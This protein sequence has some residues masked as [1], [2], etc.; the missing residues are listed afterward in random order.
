MEGL[1]PSGPLGENSNRLQVLILVGG[2]AVLC[3]ALM[4]GAVFFLLQAR[5]ELAAQV[6]SLIP[7]TR[8]PVPTATRTRVPEPSSTP[9]PPP[10]AV[11]PPTEAPPVDIQATLAVQNATAT[12]Q[13]ERVVAAAL[14]A[15]AEWPIVIT[16]NFPADNPRGWEVGTKADEYLSV[17]TQL[18][19]AAYQWKTIVDQNFA[20][21]NFLPESG[22]TF[23][24]FY[25]RVTVRFVKGADDSSYAY[26]LVF[27]SADEEYGFC[28][29]ASDGGVRVLL[30]TGGLN[31][32]ESS[33]DAI[34]PSGPNELA[35]SAI[36]SDFVCFV[37]GV[38]VHVFSDEA[39][40]S[41]EIGLGVDG[42][43]PGGESVVEFSNFEVRAAP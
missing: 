17:T 11:P 43:N 32:Y 24:D 20:Y 12:A 19:G 26:G 36:G 10:T 15:Q 40:T 8:T 16:D 25:A 28:G 7:A 23:T 22:E 39:L 33:S 1:T 41:G 2:L 21:F 9:R 4:A 13:A 30:I 31:L 5:P 34:R 38:A 14:A 3:L 29:I 35:V 37:N 27:R 42:L 6:N 18:T